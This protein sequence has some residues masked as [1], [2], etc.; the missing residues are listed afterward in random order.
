MN[1]YERR[2]DKSPAYWVDDY[3]I[4]KEVTWDPADPPDG[5]RPLYWG[6]SRLPKER[7]AELYEQSEGKP[8]KFA[9]LIEKEHGIGTD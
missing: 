4:F 7:L 2:K 3:G 5:F 9:R 6:R 8:L 1:S